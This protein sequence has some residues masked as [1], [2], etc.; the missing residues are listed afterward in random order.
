MDG[1][2]GRGE[3]T[4]CQGGWEAEKG[5]PVERYVGP[6]REVRFLKRTSTL[7]SSS[8]H[9]LHALTFDGIKSGSF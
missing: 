3:V 2:L 7:T 6:G 4:R 1:G 5:G 8:N 9:I